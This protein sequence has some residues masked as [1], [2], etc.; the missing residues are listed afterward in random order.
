MPLLSVA[1]RVVDVV[2]PV[3]QIVGL[4]ATALTLGLSTVTVT[5]LVAVQ[6]L[7]SVVVIVYACVE[8][9][10]AVGFDTVLELSPADGVQA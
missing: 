10:V 6:P 8:P 5:V 7:A 4:V 9:G 3:V 2:V 1:V